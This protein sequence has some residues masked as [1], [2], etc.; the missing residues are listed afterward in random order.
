MPESNDPEATGIDY[1][2]DGEPVASIRDLV[3]A[4]EQFAGAVGAHF[5]LSNSENVAMRELAVD[6]SLTPGDIAERTGLTSS[7]VTNLVDRMERNG[8]V[9]RR[10]HPDDRRSVLVDLTAAGKEALSWVGSVAVHAYDDIAE[11]DLPNV[12]A[13]IR[14]IAAS[15]QL[16]A[17]RIT[18]GE[19]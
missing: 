5:G 6:G 15:L 12:M 3:S 7:S 2:A 8:H 18:R 11:S 4:V 14:K 13:A 19:I 17:G 9:R 16:Q 1:C 10:A